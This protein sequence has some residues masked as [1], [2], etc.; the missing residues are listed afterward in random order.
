MIHEGLEN[1]T[2]PLVL[3]SEK[4]VSS[5][6]TNDRFFCVVAS[7]VDFAIYVRLFLLIK[8]GFSEPVE[9][10]V[11]SKNKRELDTF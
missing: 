11:S 10:F 1:E 5:R 8:N 9:I 4:A 6:S 7:I 2:I 3:A